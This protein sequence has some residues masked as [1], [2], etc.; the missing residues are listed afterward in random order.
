MGVFGPN[1]IH[2]LPSHAALAAQQQV[3]PAERPAL[4]GEATKRMKDAQEQRVAGTES[5]DAVR[6]TADEHADSEQES[7]DDGG[8]RDGRRDGF[9]PSGQSPPAAPAP[10]TTPRGRLDLRA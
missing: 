8:R 3:R 4:V 5:E 2:P 1:P 9:V 6:R 7:R 10:V